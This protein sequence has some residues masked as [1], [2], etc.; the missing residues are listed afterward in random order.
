MAVLGVLVDATVQSAGRDANHRNAIGRIMRRRQKG[1]GPIN[2]LLRR[3]VL[4]ECGVKPGDASW[5]V[6]SRH[7]IS[8]A[9]AWTEGRREDVTMHRSLVCME[10]AKCM[11]Q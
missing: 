6:V 8:G 3:H 10:N 11:Q 7:E 1:E 2:L 9:N 4:L 5:T